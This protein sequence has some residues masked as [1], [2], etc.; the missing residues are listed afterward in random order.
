MNPISS[1]SHPAPFT[2]AMADNK[3]MTAKLDGIP[4]DGITP[5]H[6]GK[7][8]VPTGYADFREAAPFSKLEITKAA[9]ANTEIQLAE[10][11]F[12]REMQARDADSALKQKIETRFQKHNQYLVNSLNKIYGNSM[13]EVYGTS[14]RIEDALEA[15]IP[16][17]IKAALTPSDA[18]IYHRKSQN[19]AQNV[20][21]KQTYLESNERVCATAYLDI[22]CGSLSNLEQF[23][24]KIKIL[25]IDMVHVLPT[26]YPGPKGLDSEGNP[27]DDD[28]GY[29][30]NSHRAVNPRLGFLSGESHSPTL[31]QIFQRFLKE[32]IRVIADFTINHTSEQSKYYKNWK[33]GVEKYKNFYIS[34]DDAMR[35][36]F[37]EHMFPFFP[38]L[39]AGNF[40]YDNDS[41]KYCMNRF[42]NSQKDLNWRNPLVAAKLFSDIF[43]L[44]KAGADVRIDAAPVMFKRLGTESINLPEVF[45]LMEAL[46]AAME[47]VA[48]SKFIL[49]ESIN[50]PS[51]ILPFLA[52]NRCEMSYNTAISTN[53]LPAIAAQDVT[54]L[55]DSLYYFVQEPEVEGVWL[56]AGRTHDEIFM[57]LDDVVALE[58]KINKPEFNTRMHRFFTDCHDGSYARGFS[59]LSDA[60]LGQFSGTLASLL[61]LEHALEHHDVAAVDQAIAN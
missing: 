30:I 23:I 1:S 37:E 20:V 43:F 5:V 15:I 8:L 54:L 11:I 57:Q 45:H 60:E 34:V 52:K 18:L 31:A 51:M 24:E 33:A 61:G 59:F 40:T 32:D 6:G 53:N 44:A 10:A 39:R 7:S 48:P 47:I 25:N 42:K 19:E 26:L 16:K 3:Q 58:N 38:L 13:D 27:I 17:I 41:G 36:K 12:R 50:M 46:R 4:P 29:A 21:S 49:A 56:N 14:Y 9:N 55:R 28:G 35:K 22:T 2:R